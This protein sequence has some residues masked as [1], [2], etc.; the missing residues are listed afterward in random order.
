[1]S[2]VWTE[3]APC[4]RG[5]ARP[6]RR[7][8]R[9][10]ARAATSHRRSAS[11]RRRRRRR[12]PSPCSGSTPSSQ[13][14]R[15]QGRALGEVRHVV[16]RVFMSH[17]GTSRRLLGEHVAHLV[18]QHLLVRGTPRARVVLGGADEL[19]TGEAG[20]EHIVLHAHS[21]PQ[22]LRSVDRRLARLVPPQPQPTA[23][24]GA[25]CCSPAPRCSFPRLPGSVRDN[26]GEGPGARVRCSP[27]ASARCQHAAGGA[28]ASV[29]SPTG[30]VAGLDVFLIL[31]SRDQTLVHRPHLRVGVA[32]ATIGLGIAGD[33]SVAG[34]GP[35]VPSGEGQP[36]AAQP[37]RQWARL[38]GTRRC[39]DVAARSRT[40]CHASL[41]FP[42][43]SRRRSRA[44]ARTSRGP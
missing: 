24:G 26:G 8:C 25:C 3:A 22:P 34:R 6:W 31:P 36:R 14:P 20:V 30:L 17:P 7:R 11:P 39:D 16:D 13:S 42:A 1:M 44:R 2:I 12:T 28:M 5:A 33:T 40:R 37:P 41:T 27:R 4:S 10:R 19:G 29:R 35:R 43:A 18:E 21:H 9:S 38:P 15:G 23:F 32:A